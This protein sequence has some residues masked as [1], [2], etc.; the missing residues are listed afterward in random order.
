MKDADVRRALRKKLSADYAGDC[1]TRIVEEMGIW[2]GSVRIDVAVINGE[3]IGYE[4]KSDLDTLERLPTQADLYS[5]V[6]DRVV[7]VVGTRH[8]AKAVPM[9]PAWWGVLLAHDLTNNVELACSRDALLNPGPDPYLVAQLLWKDEAL[10]VLD[11][12][13]LA[14]GW[15]GKRVKSIHQRL[16][17]ELPFQLLNAH[18]RKTLK[19]RAD[20]LRKSGTRVFD[21]AINANLN[22]AFQVGLSGT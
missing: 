8:A 19:S 1:S 20:W 9:V 6:F 16:A 18:V 11:S 10:E 12:H 22:P 14:R 7:L 5:K 4:L 21:V 15:R 13:G 17:N 2:S 3:L